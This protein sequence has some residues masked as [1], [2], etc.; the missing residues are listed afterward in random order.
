ME[1]LDRCHSLVQQSSATG[2]SAIEIAKKLDKHR[3]TIHG[4]LNTLFYTGRVENRNGLWYPK[5]G[6]QI[7]KPLEKEIVIELP[8]PKNMWANIAVLEAHAKY[9][10]DL[11]PGG[12]MVERT[13]IE[14]FNETRIIRI[15]GKNV[16]DIDLVKIGNLIQQANQ[17][18]SM[19]NLKGLFKG[20]KKSL[21]NSTPINRE[22]REDA[23]ENKSSET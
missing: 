4:Y 21:P 10:E 3:T 20:F 19:F 8:I 15:S 14:K 9:V 11:V 16:E 17:K 6:A 12:A 2:I 7:I 18:S 1:N 5:N 23:N 13:L 22:K